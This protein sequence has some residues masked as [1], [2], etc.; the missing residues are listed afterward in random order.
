MNVS[1]KSY[2]P[3]LVPM[4]QPKTHGVTTPAVSGNHLTAPDSSDVEWSLNNGGGR[5][6]QYPVASDQENHARYKRAGFKFKLS[7]PPKPGKPA[8]AP[9]PPKP[10][11]PPVGPKSPKPIGG[12][13]GV[14]SAVNNSKAIGNL[15]N[16]NAF[17]PLSSQLAHSARNAL[18]SAT[19]GT[20]IHLP[21]SVAEHVGSKAIADRIDAQAEMPGAEKKNA[22]GTVTTVD[23]SATQQQKLDA[24]L[25]GAE[26]KT[27]LMVNNILSINEGKDAKAMGKDPS[28][29][30]DTPSRLA[31]LEKRMDAIEEQMQD[32]GERYGIIYKPYAAPDSSQVPTDESRMKNIDERYAY[33]NKMTKV[34]NAARN[35][36]VEDEE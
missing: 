6:S 24:R 1:E 29:P 4:S 33:M 31:A 27:E 23:P 7:K 11:K 32:I 20:L 2:V 14:Q 3:L 18:I 21:F 28:A 36:T 16:A 26:I 12:P 15:H 30:T 35:A 25:E 10:A 22:D 19:V 13:N 34:L 17:T 8:V 5:S 9:K